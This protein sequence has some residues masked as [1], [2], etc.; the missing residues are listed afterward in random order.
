MAGLTTYVPWLSW[1]SVFVFVA[2]TLARE[3]KVVDDKEMVWRACMILAWAR[4]GVLL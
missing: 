1:L 3:R 2:V 4:D